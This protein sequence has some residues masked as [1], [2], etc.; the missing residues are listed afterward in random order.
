M[1]Q[2]SKKP[3]GTN[4]STHNKLEPNTG[5]TLRKQAPSSK[6]HT[7]Y[8]AHPKSKEHNRKPTAAVELDPTALK[9]QEQKHTLYTAHTKSKENATKQ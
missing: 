4:N 6:K 8:T 9:N 7:L 2:N 3:E 5:K 1:Q